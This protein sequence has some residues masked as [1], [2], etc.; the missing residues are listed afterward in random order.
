M[1]VSKVQLADGTVLVD[2]TSDNV[3]S[4]KMLRG[5]RA[6][7]KSGAVISGSITTYTG[8]GSTVHPTRNGSLT[9]MTKNMYVANNLTVWFDMTGW[10]TEEEALELMYPVGSIYMSTSSTPPAFGGEWVEV[11]IHNT[12][13]DIKNG[14]TNYNTGT[15]SGNVHYWK[16]VS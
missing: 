15:G 13:E 10:Y 1:A 14:D 9:L 16:R 5:Y 3:A 4:D 7:N 6:H 2:L 8:T 12:W 11:K